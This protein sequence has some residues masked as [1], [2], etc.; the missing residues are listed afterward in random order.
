MT[1]P[2]KLTVD[3]LSALLT[4]VVSDSSYR[5]NA[6]QLQ[7]AITP[8]NGLSVAAD[9]IEQALGSQHECQRVDDA[10][11]GARGK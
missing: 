5:D 3:H 8:A 1:S 4:E 6:R 9:L 2:D 11:V 7:K 10:E